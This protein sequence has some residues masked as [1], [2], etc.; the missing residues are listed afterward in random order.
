MATQLIV[1]AVLAD[2]QEKKTEKDVFPDDKRMAPTLA[3]AAV[4]NEIHNRLRYDAKDWFTWTSEDVRRSPAR[5]L[6]SL[7]HRA[8]RHRD[9]RPRRTTSSRGR[10]CWRLAP[11]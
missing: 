1:A 9:G 2:Q 5:S 10:N 3:Q 7:Q 4:L 6:Y 11:T 8:S